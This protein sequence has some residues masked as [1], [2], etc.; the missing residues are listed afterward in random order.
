MFIIPVDED[1]DAEDD[2]EG[3][4]VFD[5]KILI[6][7]FLPCFSFKRDSLLSSFSFEFSVIYKSIQLTYFSKSASQKMN[8]KLYIIILTRRKLNES[9]NDTQLQFS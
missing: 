8:E 1:D 4:K 9:P 6:N 2:D 7:P 5:G 3:N